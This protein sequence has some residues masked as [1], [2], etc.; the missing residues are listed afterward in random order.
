MKASR[1]HL[2]SALARKREA[3]AAQER[4]VSAAIGII[5]HAARSQRLYRRR[6][7]TSMNVDRLTRSVAPIDEALGR[8]RRG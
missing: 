4:L 2:L 5:R 8:E 1:C 3:R 7:N 6:S